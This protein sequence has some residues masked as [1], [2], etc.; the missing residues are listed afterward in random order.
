MLVF[1]SPHSQVK[2][3]LEQ[4]PDYRVISSAVNQKE[5]AVIHT[6]IATNTAFSASENYLFRF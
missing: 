1:G 6:E 3:N 5:K 4:K 2:I